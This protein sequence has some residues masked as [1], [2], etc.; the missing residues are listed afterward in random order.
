M[1]NNRSKILGIIFIIFSIIILLTMNNFITPI[2]TTEGE[3]DG[4]VA[5]FF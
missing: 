2:S 4:C 1:K 3:F 5:K